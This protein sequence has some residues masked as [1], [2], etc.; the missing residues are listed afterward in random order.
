V[1]AS[2]E[3][4]QGGNVPRVPPHRVSAGIYYR[5]ANWFSRPGSLACAASD[6]SPVHLPDP[7]SVPITLPA[8]WGKADILCPVQSVEGDD[9]W[10][11]AFAHGISAPSR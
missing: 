4:A 7:G 1:H 2:F 5:D 11:L 10:T 8:Y 6:D 3:D 9:G